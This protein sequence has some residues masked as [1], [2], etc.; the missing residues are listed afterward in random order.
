MSQNLGQ[1]IRKDRVKNAGS[2][3]LE[4]DSIRAHQPVSAVAKQTPAS[5]L[6][7]MAQVRIVETNP[8]QIV[9]E[10]TCSCG[11]KTYIQCD[12]NTEK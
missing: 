6:S 9:L 5:G 4:H 8:Q 12:Y 10:F 3:R 1:I 7:N 2:C 11:A